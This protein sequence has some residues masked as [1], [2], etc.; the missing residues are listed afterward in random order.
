MLLR[1]QVS[2][3]QLEFDVEIERTKRRNCGRRRREQKKTEKR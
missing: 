2:Q 1:G 3:D